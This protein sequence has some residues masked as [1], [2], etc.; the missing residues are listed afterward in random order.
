[1]K[2]RKNKMTKLKDYSCIRWG[3]SIL[4][5]QGLSDWTVTWT[6]GG[7]EGIALFKTRNIS[8]HW[9]EGNPD[10][11][12]MLHEIA[13]A[14]CGKPGHDSEYAHQYMQLVREYFTPNVVNESLARSEIGMGKLKIVLA[15]I[16]VP[17]VLSA[18][19][20]K[21][22]ENNAI[23]A[24]YDRANKITRPVRPWLYQQDGEVHLVWGRL[25]KNIYR[26]H[27][28]IKTE[29]GSLFVMRYHGLSDRD[30]HYLTKGN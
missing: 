29:E 9:P 24:R 28:L 19:F 10:Y 12:L 23:Y 18:S 17:L 27:I 5:E 15:L 2:Q 30:K 8:I 4:R 26:T 22:L 21:D 3:E 14:V 20:P 7:A 13:H 1:M 11:A 25:I 6:P 16:F